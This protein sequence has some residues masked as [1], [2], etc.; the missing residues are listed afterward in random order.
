M[1][2]MLEMIPFYSNLVLENSVLE[3]SVLE[4]S[5]LEN[6]VLENSVLELGCKLKPCPISKKSKRI[7]KL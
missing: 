1:R 3:N 6:S 7:F 2:V 4:N 5:V